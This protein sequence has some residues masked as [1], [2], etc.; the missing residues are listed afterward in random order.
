M[1]LDE[2]TAALDACTENEI[3]KIFDKNSKD[4][5]LIVIS[6]R[7]CSAKLSDKIALFDKGE[8]VSVGT[9]L[10]LMS[11]SKKYKQMF[12]LQADKYK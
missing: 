9:H 11:S 10:E 6:H 5:I 8:I 12:N 7:M 4:K 1:I 3:F 2:P